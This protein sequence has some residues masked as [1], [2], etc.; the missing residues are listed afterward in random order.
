MYRQVSIALKKLGFVRDLGFDTRKFTVIR[1][2]VPANIVAKL[3]RDLRKQPSGWLLAET[4]PELFAKL[5]DGTPTPE[6]VK[7]FGE[8]VPVRVV[9][10]L[11]P[12]EAAVTNR[13]SRRTTVHWHGL[14]V[15][16]EL[17]GGP[18]QEIAPGDTWSPVLPVRQPAATLWYHSHLHHET[19]SQ[20]WFGLAGLLIVRDAAEEALGLP[21]D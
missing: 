5:P 1:G 21:S 19:A 18:H 12:V 3:L 6:L 4:A 2:A 13:L 9:E 14:L 8:G 17:D 20:V 16:G 10:I 7:P 15:P 11:G